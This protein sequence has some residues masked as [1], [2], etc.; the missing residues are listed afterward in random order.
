MV[1]PPS[2][3]DEGAI[4]IIIPLPNE[5]EFKRWEKKV[6]EIGEFE[7]IFLPISQKFEKTEFCGSGGI[8]TVL[9]F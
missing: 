6:K 5:N 2:D 3:E 9:P 4:E 7:N 1:S 8:S